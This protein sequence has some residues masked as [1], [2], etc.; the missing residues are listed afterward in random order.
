MLK[1]FASALWDAA[2][3]RSS[4]PLSKAL[5]AMKYP[6]ITG[7]ET[8]YPKGASGECAFCGGNNRNGFVG[9]SAGA[10]QSTTTPGTYV[11]LDDASGWFSLFDHG[12]TKSGNPLQIVNDCDIGQFEI[13]FCSTECLR[14][15]F[16]KIVDDF[17][18][19]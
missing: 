15:F 3:L 11:P 4:A 19:L 8:S 1:S 14:G 5:N 17:E 18:N 6:L 12:I 10:M 7:E 13:F 2:L 9:I 16:N